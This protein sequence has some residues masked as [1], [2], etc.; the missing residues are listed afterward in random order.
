MVDYKAIADGDP[1]GDLQAAFDSMRAEMV[2]APYMVRVNYTDLLA[3]DIPLTTK[4][5]NLIASEV[6]LGNIPEVVH[7]RLN[8]G[9]LDI[10]NPGTQ[11]MLAGYVVASELTQAEMNTITALGEIKKYPDLVIPQIL[12]NARD[13]RSSGAI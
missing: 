12:Q 5:S 8:D 9:G 10:N 13:A 11:A 6:S 2:T 4:L 1:G 7:I 3:I